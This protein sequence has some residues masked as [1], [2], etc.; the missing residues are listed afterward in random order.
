[1]ISDDAVPAF[2]YVRIIPNPCEPNS[3]SQV[4]A[5]CGCTLRSSIRGFIA[6]KTL[7]VDF[8]N[9]WQF[10][11]DWNS[12]IARERADNEFCLTAAKWRCLLDKVRTFFAENPAS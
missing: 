12:G 2:D 7:S 11:A 5:R 8:K 10:V 1:M 4:Q 9:P 6:D 3:L